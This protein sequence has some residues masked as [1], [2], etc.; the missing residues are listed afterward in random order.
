MKVKLGPYINRFTT[1]RLDN[2]WYK[3]RYGVDSHWSVDDDQTDKWDERYEKVSGKLQSLLNATVN[4]L[5]DRRKRKIKVKIDY[6]DVWG[7]D[8]TLALIILPTLKKLKEVKHG[9][10]FVDTEDVPENLRPT[11]VPDET[12]GYTDNT[13]HERWEW[14][15]SEMIWAFEQLVDEDN[16][17]QF[18]D[19]SEADGMEDQ[20][21]PGTEA[22]KKIKIDHDG[23]KAHNERI[24]RGTILFGK[25]YRG[26]WD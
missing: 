6:Y 1:T 12:N 5:Q 20:G 24:K 13:V 15:L 7:A 25:Y 16:D 2:L 8:H 23:L 4:K 11:D 14:V 9:S 26:L 10:P 3:L 18:F 21:I 19:H 22:W 17:G